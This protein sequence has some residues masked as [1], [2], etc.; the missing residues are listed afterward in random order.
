MEFKVNKLDAVKQEVEFELSYSDLAP[1]FDKAIAKYAKKAEIP[2]FRKGKAP[3]SM[4]KRMYGDMIE[5]ASLEDVAN[6]VYK[7]YLDEN[8]VH[9]LGEAQMIDIDYEPKQQFKF[10]I[11]YEVKP[12]FELADYKGIEV[13]KT[14]YKIDDKMIEDEVRYIQ[15]KHVTYENAEKAE[16]DEFTLSMDVQK[17]DESGDDL[18][19]QMDKDVRFYLNDPQIN[20]ELKEQLAEISVGE[21]RILNLPSQEEDKTEKYRVLCKKIEK[22]VFPELNEEFFKNFY[23]DDDIKTAEE[24]NAKVK[25]DLEGI[26]K[27][28][29]VQEIRNNIVSELIK[30]N[31]ITVPETMVEHV[32]NSYIDD[33]K[34]QN[35]KRQLPQEFDEAEYRKQKRV[36]AVLQ[37]KWYLIKDKIIEAEKMEVNESDLEKIIEADAKK[38]NLPPEKLKGI[39]E[40]KPDIKNRILDDKL[41]NFLVENSK[42][43]E[44]EKTEELPEES[45]DEP[46]KKETKSKKTNKKKSEN[47][48]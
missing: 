24:F 40:N 36:D 12:E 14:V 4:I 26:Y 39:Y 1:H 48:E 43:I 9:P 3:A 28:I 13:N 30:L 17:L 34:N 2:G 5:Q 19:D 11:K 10:K 32:L 31:D 15:S 22:V 41:M 8:H 33:V 20:K 45:E 37:V 29:G 38:F 7:Q 6:E 46:G 27:N 21:E 18:K 44:V 35:P 23:K 25:I 42:I 16:G 47:S